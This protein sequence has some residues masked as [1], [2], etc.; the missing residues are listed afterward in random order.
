MNRLQSVLGWAGAA[1]LAAVVAA[2]LL[3]GF[4]WTAWELYDYK[5]FESAVSDA[6]R[7]MAI[8]GYAGK[9]Q[10]VSI[11]PI[12]RSRPVTSI[13]REAFK[14]KGI[15]RVIIPN[16]VATIGPAAF[17]GNQLNSITIGANVGLSG[18]FDNSF[19][20]AYNSAGKEA[21]TYI[22]S[23]GIWSKIERYDDEANFKTDGEKVAWPLPSS[24]MIT[25]YVG[26]RRSVRI[27]PQ[28]RGL[29]VTKI[30][31]RVFSGSQ[32]TDVTI[33]NTVTAIGA[34]AFAG[35]QLICVVIPNNVVEIGQNAFS[36]NR[37]ISVTI[38]NGVVTIGEMAFNNNLL[39]GIIIPNSVTTINGKAFWKNH[40][41]SVTIPNSV[42]AIGESAFRYNQLTE[43]II[44]NSITV[45]ENLVFANNR[46][47][48][49]TIPN[50]VTAI[51][52]SAF[53]NNRLTNVTI[54]NSVT[55]I[56]M[57]AFSDNPLT[58]ITIGAD[59]AFPHPGYQT[60]YLYYFNRSFDEAY[61]SSG[62][63]AGTYVLSGDVWLR[64]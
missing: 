40:L 62:R 33:P 9:K 46:L 20:D 38:P 4:P 18:S 57:T 11:P 55:A 63:E 41:T 44:S 28:L 59:V 29:P 52:W 48:D 42:T 35:N 8:T 60:T 3:L 56:E 7:T 45:I 27:P 23:D 36:N 21:G 14:E 47:T 16:C 53:A 54:P 32:L 25:E 15:V 13:E 5:Y 6:G 22:L 49:V 17:E 24:V 1:G 10:R 37:L 51:G 19:D 30:G 58:S 61:K 34:G 2:A 39:T 50:S 64:Q 26:E 12:M 31:E 43:V